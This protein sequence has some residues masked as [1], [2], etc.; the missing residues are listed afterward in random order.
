MGNISTQCV[1]TIEPYKGIK[2]SYLTY[3]ITGG[4]KT[5]SLPEYADA[6]A[7]A[8]KLAEAGS[9]RRA[10]QQ[11]AS[12]DIK[13]TVAVKE[14]TYQRNKYASPQLLDTKVTATAIWERES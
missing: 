6:L 5:F 4:P 1:I 7:E 12:G 13:V 10:R 11:G 2:S 9:V 14:N 8:K 3:V